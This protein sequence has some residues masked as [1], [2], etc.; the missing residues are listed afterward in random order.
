VGTRGFNCSGQIAS[1]TF[2]ENAA[3]VKS[4]DLDLGFPCDLA[5]F[6]VGA[7]ARITIAYSNICRPNHLDMLLR[8]ATW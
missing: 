5:G 8:Q 1:R 6:A 4:V 7:D 2:D 3:F